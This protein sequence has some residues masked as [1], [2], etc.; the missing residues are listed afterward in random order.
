MAQPIEAVK[1]CPHCANSVPL[2]ALKC[3]YCKADL[4]AAEA[5]EWPARFAQAADG[6]KGG[7]VPTRTK[8]SAAKIIMAASVLMVLLL[9]MVLVVG[10]R[11]GREPAGDATAIGTEIQEKDRKIE[12]LEAE[13]ARLRSADSTGQIDELKAKLDD[14]EKSLAATKSKLAAANREIE[15][16][17]SNQNAAAPRRRADSPPSTPLSRAAEP[18]IY[19]TRRPTAVYEEPFDSAR[20]VTRIGKATRV[21]VVRS[22]RGWLEVRSKHG[23]PPGFIRSDDAM[24]VSR[25]N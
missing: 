4:E 20:V 23:N 19:E 11:Q 8:R 7:P 25:A 6:T 24:L 12:T 1:L 3:P 15:R 9:A 16:L 18:G 14:S 22:I 21:T 13:L 2:E 10:Q 17:T 5:H